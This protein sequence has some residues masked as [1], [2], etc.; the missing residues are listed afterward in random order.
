ME[1]GKTLVLSHISL[2]DVPMIKFG[3]VPA[4]SAGVL[5][6]FA[7]SVLAPWWP[8]QESEQ[9]EIWSV[10]SFHL[11]AHMYNVSGQ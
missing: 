10:Q 8:N 1:I 7:F 2:L 5:A 6:L 9:T 4:I 11:G 3:D